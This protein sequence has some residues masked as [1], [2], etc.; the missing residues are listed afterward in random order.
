MKKH[1]KELVLSGQ[2]IGLWTVLGDGL[3]RNGA[4]TALCRCDCGKEQE[5]NINSLKRGESKSCGCLKRQ[6]LSYRYRNTR[7]YKIWKN[8]RYRCNNPRFIKYAYYGGRGIKVCSRWDSFENFLKDMGECP[9][10]LSIERIDPNGDYS[11]ENCRWATLLEQHNNTRS[12][13]FLTFQGKTQTMAQWCRELGVSYDLVCDRL[14]RDWS[15][16][17]ALTKPRHTRTK[18]RSKR[19]VG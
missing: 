3:D 8:M 9:D 6:N 13:R 5:V 19:R 14:S 7:T 10:G 11:P 17:D 15:V 16:E 1:R 12:N 2:R 4:R 18:S